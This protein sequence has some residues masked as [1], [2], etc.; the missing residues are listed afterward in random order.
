MFGH[1]RNRSKSSLLFPYVG[2]NIA[3]TNNPETL[4]GDLVRGW[5]N[6]SQH[7]DIVTNDCTGKECG[8]YTQVRAILN[9]PFLEVLCAYNIELAMWERF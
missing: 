7:Y 6:E 2:E 3:V 5:Y 4:L 8:H 9:V 1:N